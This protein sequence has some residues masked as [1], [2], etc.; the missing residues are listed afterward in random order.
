MRIINKKEDSYKRHKKKKT[1]V[2]LRGK[3][4]EGVGKN[5]KAWEIYPPAIV[6]VTYCTTRC[7]IFC[8]GKNASKYEQLVS[9][10]PLPS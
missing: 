3:K 2:P 10:P 7:L 6:V 1:K 5:D 8:L 9:D 4:R